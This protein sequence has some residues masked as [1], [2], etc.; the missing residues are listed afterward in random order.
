[1][2]FT[3]IENVLSVDVIEHLCEKYSAINPLDEN[4]HYI[5]DE[6]MT[7]NGTMV[8]TWSTQIEGADRALLRT[9][10]YSNANSPF[11]QCKDVKHCD[12]AILKYPKG[13]SCPRHMDVAIGAM[14]VFLNRKWSQDKGGLFKYQDNNEWIT[15]TPKYNCA[16]YTLY[17]KQTQG[18]EHAVSEVLTDDVRCVLQVFMRKP[19]DVHVRY[20]D[21]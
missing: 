4:S 16:V 21:E 9:D 18:P 20:H 10:L 2:S 12:V 19:G 8:P 6:K 5:W 1:M 13:S 17:N 15:V 7:G 11:F 14:T 3:Y